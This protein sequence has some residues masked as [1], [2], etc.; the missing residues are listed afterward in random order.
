MA[1]LPEGE[2]ETRQKQLL[3]LLRSHPSGLSEDEIAQ[4]LGW[5]RRTVNNYLRELA[6]ADKVYREGRYWFE[7]RLEV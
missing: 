4:E 2:K 1:R 6:R 3:S 7:D 5:E